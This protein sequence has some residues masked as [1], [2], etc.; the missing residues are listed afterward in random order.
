MAKTRPI[1]RV[2][3]AAAITFVLCASY[4]S[5]QTA[6]HFAVG[7]NFS[8][9]QAPDDASE[10]HGGHSVG[11]Q[12]R[13]GH[14]KQGFGWQYGLHWYSMDIARLI[15]NG[16]TGL[17]TLRVRPL[18]GG[19]GYTHLFRSGRIAVTGDMVAGY[20][21]NSFQLDPA[22]DSAYQTRLGARS[23]DAE[24]VNTLVA[25]PE[26]KIWYDVNKKVGV[27]LDAGYVFARPDVKVSTTLGTDV[28][29]VRADTYTITF[30]LVYSVF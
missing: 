21:V 10:A 26:M 22:A 24:A 23:L 27:L 6:N 19:Y 30:G 17:G 12:W 29:H 8:T 1:L 14:D 18:M 7:V 20:A 3:P 15:G 2:G 25:A 16:P 13:I 5:A 28:H 11:L 9:T 4:A